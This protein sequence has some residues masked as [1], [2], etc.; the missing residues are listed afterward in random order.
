MLNRRHKKTN[1]KGWFFWDFWSAREDLNLR[2]P[3]PHDTVYKTLRDTPLL[4]VDAI[5]MYM[6]TVLF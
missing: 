6:Q 5:C 3:T 2:P 1:H 4:V